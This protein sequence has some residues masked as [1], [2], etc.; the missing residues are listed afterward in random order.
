V[1]EPV[2]IETL[3]VANRG[4]IALRVMRTAKRL[5][6]RTVAIHTELDAGVP[7]TRAADALVEVPSYLDIDAVVDAA[8]R[9]GATAIH[10]GYG[11]LSE[12]SEFAR[13]VEDAGLKLVGPS[14]AVMDQMGRKDAARRIAVAAGVPV[15]P[16]GEGAPYPVLVKAAA[17]GG[18]KGMRIVRSEDELDAAVAAARR[19]AQAAFGDDTLLVEKYVESG[20]HIEV[21]VIADSHGNVLHLFERDCSTQRRHQKVLEEAP[22]PTITAETRELVTRSAVAMAAQVGYENAGTVEFLLDNAT[23]EAY[24]LEMNTRL[25]VEHPVTELAVSVQGRAL[26]LVELQL[27]VAA[28]EPLPFT[29]DDVALR[30]HAIEARVYAE[31]SFGGFLPQAG[32]ASLVRW[33]TRARVDQALESGQAVT[34]SY[35]PMLGKVVAHGPDRESARKALLAALDETGILGLTTNLGF[36]RALVAREEFRD[37]TIDTAWLDTATVEPPDPD[38]AR[39]SVAWVSAMLGQAGDPNPFQA[40]GWR[41]GADPAP[42]VVALD[43]QVRVDRVRGR[44]DDHEV[45]QVSAEDHVLVLSVDGRREVTVVNVQPDALEAAHHGQRFVFERPDP[46]GDHGPVAGDGTLVAPMPGTVLAVDVAEG[47]TV[48]EGQRLG[49]LEAMK[50]ELAL[51]APFDGVV[52]HVGAATGDQVQLKHVLFE[53]QAS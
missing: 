42:Y 51:K 18:G 39:L 25:Q 29:Q 17:G 30:G 16:T 1:S 19:E 15:V 48:V 13:A 40:D 53:V 31:D 27:R 47:D 37:A 12:R 45:H 23:G 28:G 21:Q 14:A 4:E 9:S 43:R 3:L 2:E 44:V 8:R 10:P 33:S 35:D 6:I 36:L 52:T 11:F 34:T 50:M 49:V 26:D 38:V 46:F 22:A 7:H 5:G 20:R 32:T 41:S 24:F